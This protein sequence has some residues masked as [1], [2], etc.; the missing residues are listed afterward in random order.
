M[1]EPALPE[2]GHLACPV[3]QGGERAELRGIMCLASFMAVAYQPGLFQNAE[4]L[5]DG[6]LRDPGLGCQGPDRLLAF[7]AE[8][9]EDR[10]AGRIGQRSEENVWGVWH[11]DHS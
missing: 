11:Q 7:A 9:L 8:A 5:G 3:D 10:P 6:R 4:M 1:V 2:A